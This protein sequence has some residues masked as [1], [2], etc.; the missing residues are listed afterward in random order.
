[1]NVKELKEM[2]ALMNENGLVEIEIEREGQ[3]IRIKKGMAGIPEET[4]E[5]YIIQPAT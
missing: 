4:Q 1:M 2:I 5:K 3:R